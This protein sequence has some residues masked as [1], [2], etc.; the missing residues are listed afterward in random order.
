MKVNISI[1]F[2]KGDVM[3]FANIQST[4]HIDEGMLSFKDSADSYVYI[5]IDNIKVFR[6]WKVENE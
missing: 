4:P 3:F 5:P 6:T 1:D 2:K